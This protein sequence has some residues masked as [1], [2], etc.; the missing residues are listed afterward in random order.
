MLGVLLREGVPGLVRRPSPN[1]RTLVQR[2]WLVG[3]GALFLSSCVSPVDPSARSITLSPTSA[4]VT[5]STEA[6]GL[7]A[8]TGAL[9]PGGFNDGEKIIAPRT[10]LSNLPSS[11]SRSG[12]SPNTEVSGGSVA[13]PASTRAEVGAA[14]AAETAGVGAVLSESAT[15]KSP[16]VSLSDVTVPTADQLSEARSSVWFWYLLGALTLSL[17][18]LLF[19]YWQSE[20]YRLRRLLKR[21]LADWDGCWAD[22]DQ[23]LKSLSGA[24]AAAAAEYIGLTRRIYLAAVSLEDIRK[25][26]SGA[27]IQALRDA[28]IGNL[29]DCHGWSQERF[30]QIRGI[31]PESAFKLVLACESLAKECKARL[32]VHPKVG[33]LTDRGLELFQRIYQLRNEGEATQATW[34]AVQTEAT[35]LA[36]IWVKVR[37]ETTFTS[38][39]IS[40]KTK[41]AEELQAARKVEEEIRDDGRLTVA[42]RS[43][44]EALEQSRERSRGLPTQAEIAA[45][46][47]ARTEYYRKVLEVL[48]GP[49]TQPVLTEKTKFEAAVEPVLVRSSE[50]PGP[51]GVLRRSAA[52]AVRASCRSE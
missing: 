44:R 36:S 29:L 9:P 43:A 31:G 6:E 51:G 24:Q 28:G 35:E 27:R 30:Q 42:L 45:D 46:Y 16:A 40:S 39:L 10:N 34:L 11:G 19:R 38:W 13:N 52:A 26:A 50:P 2:T 22:F 48:L 4:A 20:A 18:L 33:R 8:P 17:A 21:V 14:A 12:S 23:H 37:P 49:G 1:R 7:Q 5:G 41:P 47:A 32:I 25:K 3:L 15:V